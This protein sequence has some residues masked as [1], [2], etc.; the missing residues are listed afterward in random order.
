MKIKSECIQRTKL[1]SNYDWKKPEDY[2][3][4][5]EDEDEFLEK[6]LQCAK[7]FTEIERDSREHDDTNNISIYISYSIIITKQI[8]VIN[9]N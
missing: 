3:V 4:E 5:D 1:E 8:F 7:C 6:F 9:Y 2:K